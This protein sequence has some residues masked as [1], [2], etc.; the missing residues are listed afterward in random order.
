MPESQSND[1]EM[2]RTI[3]SLSQDKSQ[4]GQVSVSVINQYLQLATEQQI[5]T[6]YLLQSLEIH[7]D[8]LNDNSHAISG[9]K[10][11]QLLSALI[12]V[13]KDPLFGLH[14]AQ[15]VQPSSYSV[16][17]FISMNCETLGEAISK[18]PS[19]EKLVGDMGLTSFDQ[20]GDCFKISWDCLYSNALVCR[21]MID[22]CLASWVNF[23][24]YLAN[25][26]TAPVKVHF[27]RKPPVKLQQQ[28]YQKLFNCPVL[29]NQRTNSIFFEKRLL[30]YPLHHGNKQL[31]STLETHANEQLNAMQ[32]PATLIE[33]TE[34]FILKNLSSGLIRQQ[35]VAESMGMS[36]KTLQRKLRAE[37]VQFQQLLDQVRLHQAKH[38]LKYSSQRLYQISQQL[39]FSETRSFHRWFLKLM[40]KT[41][42]QFRQK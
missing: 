29:F 30:D 26:K 39:G 18:I 12:S 5:A 34:Q 8:Y 19:F 7:P 37:N 9:I 1:H 23:A 4:L 10:F 36:A 13:S 31:L 16:L 32:K 40:Q 22:N 2:N 11:Q 28:E 20:E 38:Y 27:C 14:T 3:F 33:Q 21:H 41:P 35:D 25:K 24:H 42:G 6:D 17:G 15:F